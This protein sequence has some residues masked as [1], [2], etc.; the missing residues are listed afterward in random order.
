MKTKVLLTVLI[1]WSLAFSGPVLAGLPPSGMASVTSLDS[2]LPKAADIDRPLFAAIDMAAGEVHTC[3]VSPQNEVWCWGWNFYGQLGEMGLDQSGHPRLVSGVAGVQALALSAGNGHTCVLTT[4]GSV[5]C[6]GR[7][8]YGHLGRGSAG[9]S[10]PPT[11]VD[12]LTGQPV[13]ALAAGGEHTCALLET[14]QAMC[15]GRNNFGQLGD[16]TILHQSTP[17]M[18]EGLEGIAALTAG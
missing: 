17:V 16:G 13:A 3:A 18:V 5:W 11:V 15:W 12:G 14:G 2:S 10:G 4:G 9:H 7:N 1:L 6:W 8:D